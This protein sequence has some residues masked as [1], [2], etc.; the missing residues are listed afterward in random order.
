MQGRLL[1]KYQ[2]RYQAHPVG[3]WQDEFPIAADLG[4]DCVEFIFDYNDYALNPLWS[5]QGN[6]EIK[7]VIHETGVNV[8]SVC[9]DFFMECP[10][11]S[12]DK[13]GAE[14]SERILSKLIENANNLEIKDI[15]LPCV[16]QSSLSSEQ[17]IALFKL[18]IEKV[19]P[20]AEKLGVNLCLETD[21]PPHAFS[22]LLNDINSSS[23]TVNYDTGNS[24]SLG[25]DCRKE[26]RSYGD[27]ITDLHIKDRSLGGGS[28]FFGDG[29]VDFKAF[30][31][32]LRKLK[33]DGPVIMQVFRDAE[34]VTA[35]AEQ[36][37]L[38][39]NVISKTND[40]F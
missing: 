32:E 20:I 29:D 17:D 37:N 36:L 23:V 15:V 40:I 9:A 30:F 24:A 35:F 14:F 31:P 34:G 5:N 6:R 13:Q 18:Q 26:L 28:V 33:F 12:N 3:Y 2:D 22:E 39:C 8:Y 4:L 27:K 11:H 1:P 7:N 19:V 25:Y 38:L 16:D 10:L 21:L